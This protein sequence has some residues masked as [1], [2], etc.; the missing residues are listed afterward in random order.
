MNRIIPFVDLENLPG[1][2]AK[3]LFKV[4]NET[5]PHVQDPKIANQFTSLEWVF[6]STSAEIL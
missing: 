4:L 2:D 3:A 6:V 5:P 1:D